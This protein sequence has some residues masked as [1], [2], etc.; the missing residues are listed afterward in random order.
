MIRT[1][2]KATKLG[3]PAMLNKLLSRANLR[4]E[5]VRIGSLAPNSSR[6]RATSH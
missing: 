4:D 5:F 1:S 2:P 6:M 3:A